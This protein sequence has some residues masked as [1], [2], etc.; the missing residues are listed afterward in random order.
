MRFCMILLQI[1]LKIFDSY[2]RSQARRLAKYS[3]NLQDIFTYYQPL[4]WQ[5]I[6]K[7]IKDHRISTKIEFSGLK[8]DFIR[9][10]N[11]EQFWSKFAPAKFRLIKYHRV[12]L[13]VMTISCKTQLLFVSAA[14]IIKNLLFTFFILISPYV[15]TQRFLINFIFRNDITLSQMM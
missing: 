1:F 7:D 5:K 9:K 13:L 11:L 3:S 4:K 12:T 10:K 14:L 2:P 15:W 8:I 6:C